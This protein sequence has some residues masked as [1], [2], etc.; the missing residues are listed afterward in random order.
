[1]C[2]SS[3][4]GV[5]GVVA[6]CNQLHLPPPSRPTPSSSTHVL[7]Y[8]HMKK[9]NRFVRSRSLPRLF[10]PFR[11]QQLF[12]RLRCACW[13]RA[14]LSVPS[15]GGFI[16]ELQVHVDSRNEVISAL[17]AL[18]LLLYSFCCSRLV[19]CVSYVIEAKPDHQQQAQLKTRDRAMSRFGQSTD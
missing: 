2:I 13:T 1:M 4:S 10:L 15:L 5:F 19:M 7:L 6:L 12:H 18:A 3:S 14:A 17:N 8:H 16:P 9:K 11:P